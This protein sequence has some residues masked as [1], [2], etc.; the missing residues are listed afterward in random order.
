[1]R[2]NLWSIVLSIFALLVVGGCSKDLPKVSNAQRFFTKPSAESRNKA[3][4]LQI[5]RQ[6]SMRICMKMKGFGFVQDLTIS[7]PG[8][9]KREPVD[10]VL[11]STDSELARKFG[12]G[13]T[14]SL[15]SQRIFVQ[16]MDIAVR[17]ASNGDPSSYFKALSGPQGCAAIA[18][19]AAADPL[20]IDAE[21]I[22][23]SFSSFFSKL[24][25]D[26]DF[27]N[28]TYNWSRCMSQR[29]HRYESPIQLRE[30]LNESFSNRTFDVNLEA[31]DLQSPEA[32]VSRISSTPSVLSL[33]AEENAIAK[34]D[35]ECQEMTLQTLRGT[36]KKFQTEVFGDI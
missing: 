23:K 19:R 35:S 22:D 5:K 36:V 7:S 14:S 27:E 20:A 9:A 17:K 12:Y 28:E 3:S 25:G 32:A 31:A 8:R 4:Q 34:D 24:R 15:I 21:A 13:I 1:M 29:G 10:W 6:K 2:R 11:F 26:R 16:Y 30:S 18:T 33:Q